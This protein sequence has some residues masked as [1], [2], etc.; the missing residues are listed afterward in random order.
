M[1]MTGVRARRVDGAEVK[2][3]TAFYRLRERFF[4]SRVGSLA[5]S[6]V[7]F[8]LGTNRG[9]VCGTV[10]CFSFGCVVWWGNGCVQPQG[11]RKAFRMSCTNAFSVRV[12]LRTATKVRADPA[13]LT[14]ARSASRNDK[15]GP[16]EAWR[17]P[18]AEASGRASGLTC[19]Y[20][21][22][23]ALRC[24][25]PKKRPRRSCGDLI[26]ALGKPPDRCAPAEALS[27]PARHLCGSE[28]A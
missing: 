20:N 23:P 5:F 7:A 3:D 6:A 24:Q 22:Y 19:G 10:S 1:A 4:G 26:H 12:R 11:R 13:R 18:R 25:E 21:T 16:R 14:S 8:N 9:M 2:L 28:S 17:A 27:K 15:E